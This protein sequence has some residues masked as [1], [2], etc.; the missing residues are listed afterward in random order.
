MEITDKRVWEL[1][2]RLNVYGHMCGHKF[3]ITKETN[4]YAVWLDCEYNTAFSSGHTYKTL[5]RYVDG[6]RDMFLLLAKRG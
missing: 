4:G 5:A 3:Q 6:L 1:M 2:G